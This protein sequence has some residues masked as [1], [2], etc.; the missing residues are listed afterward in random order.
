MFW[1]EFPEYDLLYHPPYKLFR[2]FLQNPFPQ[3]TLAAFPATARLPGALGRCMS[4]HLQQYQVAHVLFLIQP[5]TIQSRIRSIPYT[6]S[7]HL[8]EAN[9]THLSPAPTDSRA[10]QDRA[11]MTALASVLVLSFDFVLSKLVSSYF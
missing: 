4:I 9:A 6:Q 1:R 11:T 10:S 2:V 8:Y 3:H 7:S 5:S